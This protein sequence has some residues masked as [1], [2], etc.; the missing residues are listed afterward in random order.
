LAKAGRGLRKITQWPFVPRSGFRVS[1][2]QN[3]RKFYGRM[4]IYMRTKHAKND[5][6][7]IKRDAVSVKNVKNEYGFVLPSLTSLLHT[8]RGA[9]ARAV[10]WI[11]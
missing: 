7:A 9:R 11:T 2:W 10:L 8:P 3:A 4:S 5:T 6:K 1:R